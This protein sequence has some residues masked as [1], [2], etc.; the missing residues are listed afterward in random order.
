MRARILFLIFLLSPAVFYG[1]S[2]RILFLGNSYTYYNN[3]PQLV[4]DVAAAAGDSVFFDSNTMGGAT[5][6]VHSIN[7][8]SQNKIMQGNW[9][10]VILQG[11]STELWGQSNPYPAPAAGVLDSM[12]NLYNLCGETMFYMTWGRKNG[13]GTYTY[14]EM[15]TMIFRNYMNLADTLKGVVSPVAQVWKYIR[16]T[17]PS[18]ELYDP[19][20]SHPSLA[21]SYAAACCFYSAIFR[22]DPT[23]ST[24]N[25]TL[26][27]A[28]ASVIKNAA[29]VVVY[30]SLMKWHIGEYDSIFINNNC[31]GTAV[32]EIEKVIRK[33]YPN[34]A[35]NTITL[36]SDHVPGD[37]IRLF[38]AMG[39][40]IRELEPEAVLKIEIGDL[41]NGLYFLQ[42]RGESRG[43][44]FIKQ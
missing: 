9:D 41:A 37:P 44:K 30:D 22:K 23:L 25:S 7:T 17:N 1:Q 3:M 21:G 35:G 13:F 31:P 27:A 38:N 11:Q 20:E 24:F 15:D 10:Y 14:E 42:I 33:I 29:K 32:P 40:L 43:I 34:P 12:I 5:F 39:I 18:I 36:E 6:Y 8:V 26:L 2:K 16:Q 28:D 19:D 4:A